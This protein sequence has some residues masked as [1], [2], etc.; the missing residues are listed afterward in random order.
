MAGQVKQTGTT[1]HEGEEEAQRRY[2]V[3]G[4]DWDE[5]KLRTMFKDV[6]HAGSDRA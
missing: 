6:T 2:G 3:E 1:L 5:V 4:F